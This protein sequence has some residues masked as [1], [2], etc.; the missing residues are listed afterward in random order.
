VYG[1]TPWDLNTAL[2]LRRR[3]ASELVSSTGINVKYSPGGLIDIE[4]AVQYL[5][6][7]HGGRY[8]SLRNPSTLAALRA[9][10]RCRKL[11]IADER[12]LTRTYRF[13]RRLIDALRIV[14]GNARDLLLPPADSEEFI[15]L[16][17]RMGYQSGNWALAASRLQRDIQRHM[18]GTRRF[19]N[20]RF[21]R[22]G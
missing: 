14:R 11:S 4:Y 18:A 7:L 3:Q 9:L 15:F 12:K 1:D 5:Q 2:E 13:L 8:K 17:R 21:A 16:A 22:Q 19:F 10:R 20:A 6:I